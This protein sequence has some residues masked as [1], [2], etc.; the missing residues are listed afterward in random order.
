[1][2]CNNI[3]TGNNL[4]SQFL[5]EIRHFSPCIATILPPFTYASMEKSCVPTVYAILPFPWRDKALL[6]PNEL[7]HAFIQNFHQICI[8]LLACCPCFRPRFVHS[9][10]LEA[11]PRPCAHS[12]SR[13]AWGYKTKQESE[14]YVFKNKGVST[15]QDIIPTS[16]IK[17]LSET[18][19]LTQVE[20]CSPPCVILSFHH[21]CSLNL[22]KP[23]VLKQSS[24]NT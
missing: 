4:A 13:G 21:R 24:N 10:H 7:I 15:A 23:A 3:I 9:I 20:S 2:H 16:L 12:P 6:T 8:N 1:M 5:Q 11:C 22:H 17:V 19:C 14:I 18:T